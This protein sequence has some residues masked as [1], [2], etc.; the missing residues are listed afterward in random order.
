[1][2]TIL[3][4]TDFSK[5]A[6]KAFIY[7][8]AL[9]D[10]TGARVVTMHSY[11]LP[12]L[13]RSN[14]QHTMAEVYES[15]NLETFQ[16]YRD[17]VPAL[18]TIAEENGFSAVSVQHVLVEGR[19]THSIIRQAKKDKADLIVMGTT[20]ASGL[21]E[22]FL[23][24]VAGEIMEDAPCPVLGVPIAAVFDAGLKK[25]AFGTNFQKE[26]IAAINWLASWAK[27]IN[28]QLEVVHID[29]AHT[30]E[31]SPRMPD[32][33]A[34]FSNHHHLAFHVEDAM[35]FEL[36]ITNFMEKTKA[37]IL[38]TVIHKRNFI[39][40]FFNFSK[41]KTLAYHLENPILAIP[42]AAFVEQE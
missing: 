35:D 4:P 18:R 40:E 7:A 9:A 6:N 26:E 13:R 36:G 33:S 42:A 5:A 37:D 41:T 24:S 31:L 38:A 12:N 25:I 23:G 39:Q 11:E 28:A 20:G 21:K 14:L 27:V 8:L 10:A 3:F 29:L 30:E 16:N 2:N 34:K 32:W 22:V 1:M 19:T 17:S 15:I